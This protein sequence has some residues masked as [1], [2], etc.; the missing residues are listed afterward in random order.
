VKNQLC[1]QP[2]ALVLYHYLYPDEVVSAV[3][4]TDLCV[5]LASRGWRVLASSSVR[6]WNRNN[7]RHPKRAMWKGVEFRRIWRPGLRQASSLGRLANALWMIAAWSLL[8][9][10]RSIHPDVVI[11]GTDPILS[12]VIGAVWKLF[13]PRVKLVHWC[14]DLYPEAAV[15]DGLLQKSGLLARLFTGLMGF[16]YRRFDMLV[17]IGSCM[18]RRLMRYGSAAAADTIVPWALIEP[19][20]PSPI[21][22]AERN[23]LFAEAKLGLLYSGSFGRAH[24]WRGLPEIAEALH[25]RGGRVVFSVRGSGVERLREEVERRGSP[26]EFVEF[27]PTERLMFRLSAADVHVVSLREEWTGT[28][29]PSKFFGALAIGR[30]V[31][32]LGSANSAIAKWIKQ[33]GVGW[34]LDRD[35]IESLATELI[36]WAESPTAKAKL[37]KHCHAVYQREF[38]RRRALDRWDQTLRSLLSNEAAVEMDVPVLKSFAA[39]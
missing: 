4:F 5:G 9:L 19:E 32:F 16:S 36:E 31:L 7:R 10:N 20:W 33:M 8:A 37:F 14:F 39:P 18:R 1:E 27:A 28:V 21:P 25:G 35:R 23:E 6:A 2:T 15:A 17:D 13:R 29:V 12:P 22:P 38:S 3:L 34:I 24:S 26:V 30:P 11:V